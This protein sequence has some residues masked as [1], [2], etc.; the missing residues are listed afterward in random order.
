MSSG[1]STVE[2]C[3]R[4]E[5]QL[6]FEVGG[7]ILGLPW[8]SDKSWRLCS[9]PDLHKAQGEGSGRKDRTV[10]SAWPRESSPRV[11]PFHPIAAAPC[12]LGTRDRLLL[13]ERPRALELCD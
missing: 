10:A 4:F 9:E 12:A 11:V 7:P 5:F 6:I 13:G 8:N 1:L 2:Q 3:W